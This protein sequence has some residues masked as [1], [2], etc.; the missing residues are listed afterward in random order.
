MTK[1]KVGDRVKL[2]DNII[3]QQKL[4]DEGVIVKL[5][6]WDEAANALLGYIVVYDR[7]PNEEFCEQERN[8]ELIQPSPKVTEFKSGDVIRVGPTHRNARG[9]FLNYE[10]LVNKEFVVRKVQKNE[11]S[12]NDCF[13]TIYLKDVGYWVRSDD[14]ELVSRP[15]EAPLKA[16]SGNS[17]I[18]VL[19]NGTFRFRVSR[20]EDQLDNFEVIIGTTT[21]DEETIDLLL[22]SN[23]RLADSNEA[24]RR[25]LKKIKKKLKQLLKEVEDVIVD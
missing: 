24:K 3:R 11:F 6:W 9:A 25:R 12:D 19:A 8:I 23:E 5:S 10:L 21:T 15:E 16:K 22:E 13:D 1:F 18:E 7:I 4:G 17:L 14:I 2:I 20:A